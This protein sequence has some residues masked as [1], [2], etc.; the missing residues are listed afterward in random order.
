MLKIL[1]SNYSSFLPFVHFKYGKVLK[2]YKFTSV[3]LILDW[4]PGYF[5]MFILSLSCH[6]MSFLREIHENDNKGELMDFYEFTL[7]MIFKFFTKLAI[8]RDPR[9]KPNFYNYKS[10]LMKLGEPMQFY[11]R[12]NLVKKFL[13]LAPPSGQKTKKSNYGL[14]S[15]L[16][17]L[18]QI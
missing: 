15:R 9:I 5:K 2:F 10:K 14:L 8:V 18:D 11:I 3:L 13:G 12:I 1:M 16:N 17:P 7:Y 6:D 4:I